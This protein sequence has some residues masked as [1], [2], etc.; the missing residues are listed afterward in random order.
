MSG[1]KIL[2]LLSFGFVL[3]Y[4]TGLIMQKLRYDAASVKYMKDQ[5]DAML[6]ILEGSPS[7][8]VEKRHMKGNKN[9]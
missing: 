3:G 6:K 1:V 4:I 9:V 8:K 2:L 7:N 5:C